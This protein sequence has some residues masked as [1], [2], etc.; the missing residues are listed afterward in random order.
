MHGT[1]KN[2]NP[3][4]SSSNVGSTSSDKSAANMG[5]TAAL[6]A[7]TS[8]TVPRKAAV[9][10]VQGTRRPRSNTPNNIVAA[11]WPAAAT[12]VSLQQRHAAPPAAGTTSSFHAAPDASLTVP[13]SL[14][15]PPPLDLSPASPA[16]SVDMDVVDVMAA[17]HLL[18]S[19]R[20][21][22]EQLEQLGD[23]KCAVIFDGSACSSPRRRFE[24]LDFLMVLLLTLVVGAYSSTEVESWLA[25]LQDGESEW[26]MSVRMNDTMTFPGLHWCIHLPPNAT[27]HTEDSFNVTCEYLDGDDG[28]QTMAARRCASTVTHFR[29]C[30]WHGVERR[31]RRS[32]F[33][34][35]ADGLARSVDSSGYMRV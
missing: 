1:R 31:C 14:P 8:K 22:L 19:H 30:I 17:R 15:P 23:S 10:S 13:A 24:L 7:T 18:S 6:A 5:T 12:T 28:E 3:V 16:R 2:D 35:N 26:K 32:C 34:V 25:W 4:E 29:T 11:P 20:R 9:G 27:N 33:L 21:E